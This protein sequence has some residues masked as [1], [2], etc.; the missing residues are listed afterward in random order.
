MKLTREYLQDILTYIGH[1][2]TFAADGR[3]ALYG[4]VRTRLA[5]Q[6]SYE[7]IGEIVKRLPD[8][9]LAQQ[10][11]IQWRQI[12][13]FRDVLIHQYDA[14]DLEIVAQA[15]ADLPNLRAAVTV[16]LASLPE[17]DEGDDDAED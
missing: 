6:R 8:E 15:L 2:E 10:P 7:I 16:M 4:D 14:V 9:L 17:D 1:L 11:H 5:V 3:D 12:K 13:G